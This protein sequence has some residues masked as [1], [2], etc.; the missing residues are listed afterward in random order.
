MV[1]WIPWLVVAFQ[2]ALVAGAGCLFRLMGLPVWVGL[3]SGVLCVVANAFFLQSE[4]KQ[5]GG[6]DDL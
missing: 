4:D 6:F 1:K 2:L 3:L 5:P